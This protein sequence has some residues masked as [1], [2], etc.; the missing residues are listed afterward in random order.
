MTTQEYRY[1]EIGETIPPGSESKINGKWY[2]CK[3]IGLMHRHGQCQ[4]RVPVDG[5]PETT[6]VATIFLFSEAVDWYTAA[7][8]KTA[9]ARIQE[10]EAQAAYLVAQ[11][12]YDSAT[13]DERRALKALA[14][15]AAALHTDAEQ[16]DGA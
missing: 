1:L 16:D 14:Q 7:Q 15:M 9:A 2:P 5:A 12:A 11:L 4:R 3:S 6:G 8:S 13:A 10:N